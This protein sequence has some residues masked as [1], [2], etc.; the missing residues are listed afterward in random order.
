[1]DFKIQAA[2]MDGLAAVS[3]DALVVV[4]AGDALP[5]GLDAAVAKQAQAA[6]KLSDFALKAGQTLTLLQPEGLV[7]ACAVR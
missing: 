4:L 1:M 5:K 6:L 2:E 3:A 7:A